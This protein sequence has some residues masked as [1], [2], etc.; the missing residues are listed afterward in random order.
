MGEVSEVVADSGSLGGRN[1]EDFMGTEKL[2]NTC[3]SLW[4]R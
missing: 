3:R 4:V 2:C 1:F